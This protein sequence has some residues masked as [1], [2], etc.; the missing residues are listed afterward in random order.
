MLN[1]APAEPAELTAL[2]ALIRPGGVV[3]STTVWMP[4]PAAEERG[5]RA[6]D[7]FVRNDVDQLA[8][9]VAMVDGGELRVD[10][11]DRV[12]LAELAALHTAAAAGALSGKVVVLT[13]V[14]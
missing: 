2:V 6:V 9:L 7:V 3:V 5:V 4:A 13:A 14:A 8:R 1:L 12:P 10:V 11:A